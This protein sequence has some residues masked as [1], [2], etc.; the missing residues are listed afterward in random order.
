MIA[1]MELVRELA[2]VQPGVPVLS[3]YVR[4]DP[5]DPANTAETP[6]WLVELRN[7][8]REVTGAANLEES[9]SQRL[10]RLVGPAKAKDII[11]TGRHV[12]AE[13]S[14]EIGMADAVFPDDERCL[15]CIRAS[16]HGD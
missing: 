13:E 6:K 11:F 5:R 8:L 1:S 16:E 3:L 15:S 7:G 14:L 4:I 10:A 2:T 12:G 9:R